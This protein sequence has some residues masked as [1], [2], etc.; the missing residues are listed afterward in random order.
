MGAAKTR[1]G[2]A[3]HNG[4]PLQCHCSRLQIRARQN[5]VGGGYTAIYGAG[6]RCRQHM[7]AAARILLLV[8]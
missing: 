5:L 3:L 2:V 6:S 4:V 7:Q 1:N 8:D